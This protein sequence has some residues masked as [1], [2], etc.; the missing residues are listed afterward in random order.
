MTI[1]IDFS[2][3]KVDI[4]V[5]DL[6][7]QSDAF[8]TIGFI[9]ESDTA[10]RTLEITQLSQLLDAGFMRI[11]N[12]Y[13]FV[14]SVFA[15]GKMG[16]VVVRAKRSTE[17]FEEAYKA[18][19]NSTYYYVVIDSKEIDDVLS[20]NDS[21]F[22]EQF[23]LQFFS[24]TADVSTLIQGRSKLVYYFQD[25]LFDVGLS[26]S[27]IKEIWQWDDMSNL[28][29]DDGKLIY[30]LQDKVLNN[31]LPY[32]HGDDF[33]QWD[34][35]TDVSWDDNKLVQLEIHDMPVDI[36]QAR[37][38]SFPEAA[39]VGNCGFYFPS[40]VQ[41][42][43]KFLAKVPTTK[44][45]N[46]PDLSTSSALIYGRDKATV[47]SGTTAD[48]TKI[49]YKVMNDWLI[50]AI[51]RNL[52]KILYTKEKVPQTNS[53]SILMENGLKEVLDVAVTENHFSDYRITE[54]IQDIRTNKLS[55]KFSAT[56]VHTILGVDK[57]EG[58]IYN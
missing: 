9:T 25:E 44:R 21:I 14:H 46:L 23:K 11:D 55:M 20:F 2:P 53:G 54:V 24:S 29:W 4:Q 6:Q 43:H 27:D 36:A 28:A 49:E 1:D 51:Q 42:L 5:E 41:W 12:V 45:T 10:P 35:I 48:G 57:V 15:Q 39:W 30:D 34:D 38:S 7:L 18:D 31:G 17:T 52:W 32:S 8:Y 13:N 22:Q 50:W 3:I 33:W 16:K 47:G 19:D 37:L 56:L 58:T 40:R 26:F